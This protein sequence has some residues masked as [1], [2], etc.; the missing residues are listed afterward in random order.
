MEGMWIEGRPNSPY[1]NDNE[2]EEVKMSN[3]KT[4]KKELVEEKMVEQKTEKQALMPRE[5]VFNLP[6]INTKEFGES[7]REEMVGLKM[8]FTRVKI[9][10]GG[11]LSFEVPGDDPEKPEQKQT[12]RGV[13]VDKHPANVYWADAY[14]GESNAPDCSSV[15]GETGI[16]EPGGVCRTCPYNQFGSGEGRGKACKNIFRLY[17]LVEG[18]MFPLLITLPPTSKKALNDYIS[19]SILQKGQRSYGVLTEIA[20]KKEKNSDGI[21]YSSVTFKKVEVLPAEEK[22]VLRMYSESIKALTRQVGISEEDYETKPKDI[23]S[24]NNYT[25]THRP[26]EA[27]KVISKE[28]KKAAG[29]TVTDAKDDDDLPF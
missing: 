22:E 16:G 10:S 12:L 21:V 26:A 7:I 5:P 6:Q 2:W 23:D 28:E 19:R 17:L 4:E 27:E 11:G 25:F 8:E 9:P 29:Y 24:D 1:Y 18:E 20:L 3:S 13:I 14:S 15:D